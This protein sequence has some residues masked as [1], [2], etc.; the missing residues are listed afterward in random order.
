MKIS[1]QSKA[2]AFLALMLSTTA[3]IAAPYCAVFSFGTQCYYYDWSSCQR[4]AG[5]QGACVINQEEVEPPSGSAPF[6]VVASYGTQCFYYDAGSCRQ[7][8]AQAN[9]TCA[10]NPNR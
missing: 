6:C 7:A 3:C 5:D 9:A 2:T 4:A 10:V 8:A 1:I